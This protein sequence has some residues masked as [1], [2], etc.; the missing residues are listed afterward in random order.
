MH[1][2]TAWVARV[3]LTLGVGVCIFT[4]V[5]IGTYEADKQFR[6][7]NDSQFDEVLE[8]MPYDLLSLQLQLKDIDEGQGFAT[9][10]VLPEA[11]GDYFA[12]YPLKNGWYPLFPINLQIDSAL[13]QSDQD[14]N[15]FFFDRDYQGGF[16]AVLDLA[17]D[18]PQQRS[19]SRWYPFDEYHFTFPVGGMY[20]FPCAVNFEGQ[21]CS[22]EV[23]EEYKELDP[24][25]DEDG[26]ADLPLYM[27]P[28]LSSG[29]SFIASMRPAAFSSD[30][31]QPFDA[32]KI[33]EQAT[34]G[35]TS[36]EISTRRNSTTI[37][38]AMAV[39]LLMV[40]TAFSVVLMAVVVAS[41]HRPPTIQALIWGAALTFALL[42]MRNLYPSSPALGMW[43]DYIVYFPALI[44][45]MI[46]AIW[47]LWMWARRGDFQH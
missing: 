33:A 21:E 23:I 31:G 45:T 25:V 42:Q 39:A 11:Y 24:T 35:F 46:C 22:D 43:L 14:N 15:S 44:A 7:A 28:Y 13:P 8:E 32:D 5:V 41:R 12:V 1:M 26:W 3:L 4:V 18:A 47:I 10:T 36:V 19:S 29:D 38:A 16:E 40:A 30:W 34:E 2:T 17:E 6:A 9:L 20:A 27:Y 37:M